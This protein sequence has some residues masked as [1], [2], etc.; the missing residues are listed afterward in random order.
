MTSSL[1]RGRVVKTLRRLLSGAALAA[2]A[3]AAHAQTGQPQT[4]VPG[5]S[6]TRPSSTGSAAAPEA[7]SPAEQ[8][9]PTGRDIRLSAPLR[10]GA[11]VLGDVPF[12]ITSDD[13][14][15]IN[16]ARV[17]ALLRPIIDPARA[18]ELALALDNVGEVSIERFAQFGFP[19]RYDPASIALTVEVPAAA[20]SVRQLRLA[21][22]GDDLVGQVDKPAGFSAY[23]NARGNADYVW[24]GQSKGFQDPQVLVDGAVRLA[25]V[26]LESEGTFQIGTH[27]GARSFFRREGT[28]LVYDSER[29]LARI[30]SGDLLPTSRGFS[31]SSQ[32]AGVG[33]TRA[34][35]VLQP[36]RN[37][38]PRGD[39]SFTL[40]RP[41]TVEA[42]INGQPVR[43][44]RLDPG[45]YNVS[46]FPFAQGANDVR[47]QITDDTGVSETI[48][49]SLFFD[50]TLLQPGITEFG[51]YAGILA[52]FTGRG[53][54]YRSD[55]PAAN[56]FVRRGLTQRFTGGLNFQV[57]KTG[58]VAGV[59]G[60]LASSL[61]TIGFDLAASTNRGFGSGYAFN[62]GIQRTFGGPTSR[63][64]AAALTFE[65][66]SR[67]FSAPGPSPSVNRFAWEAAATYSQSIGELQYVSINGRFSK[68]RDVDDEKSVRIGYGYRLTSQIN[69]QAEGIYEDRPTRS[70]SYG[71]RAAL[72]WRFG[73]R[74][75]ATA[76]YDTRSNR[77]RATVQTSG[78]NGVG[79]YSLGLG[80]DY[81]NGSL[82]LNGAAAYTANRAEI[83][84]AHNST[85][86]TGGTTIAE[87]RTSLRAGTALVIANGH[88][89]LSRPI[90]DSFALVVPHLTLN[91]AKV[92]VDPREEGYT[93]KSDLLG[94]AVAPDLS[95]YTDRAIT[96]DAPGAPL[97]YDLGSGNVRVFPPYRSGYL[98]TVGSDY[99]VTAIGTM[100]DEDGKPISLLAGEAAELARPDRP[101]IQIFTNREGR[102]GI[103]GLRAGKWQ[104]TMPTEPPTT[105]N[106]DIPPG[107]KGVAR[108]GELKLGVKR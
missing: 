103:Q 73:A 33:I 69:L 25:G 95:S 38:Q 104:M 74:S 39:R 6:S 32:L 5:P 31:G 35:S 19:M 60:V 40:L 46:D 34:Y 77:A 97:G 8:L 81:G 45:T 26:V 41:S 71:V 44:V 98:V 23:V 10:D 107:L 83:A 96:F 4:T 90:F 48:E 57:Q 1:R 99:T 92:V 52:P 3:A 49:F 29:L 37:I 11:F 56:G 82:G 42:F 20:R 15:L 54:D 88:F 78:G 17:L 13:R 14:I 72:T 66:R 105:I 86:D 24:T 94:G 91:G 21:Q 70:N 85:F 18:Q 27:A 106:I 50:R 93:S 100:L 108:L 79:A 30:T 102:F 7:A 65:S 12:T 58:V 87:Q 63:G 67:Y 53:R 61:G 9:N 76:E 101:A 62:I 36:Q 68:G 59:E 64:R 75:N 2:Y 51:L 47:L 55:Q 28:R 16:G 22:L 43:Q 84:I 89:A 80:A